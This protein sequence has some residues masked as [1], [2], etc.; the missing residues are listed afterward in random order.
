MFCGVL[1][2][3]GRAKHMDI[4]TF[5]EG[6]ETPWGSTGAEVFLMYKMCNVGSDLM[7]DGSFGISDIINVTSITKV[8][9]L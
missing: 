9:D 8:T 4:V 7:Q 3:R 1:R 6:K 5:H 2:P